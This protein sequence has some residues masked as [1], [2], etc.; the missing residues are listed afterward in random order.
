MRFRAPLVLSLRSIAFCSDRHSQGREEQYALLLKL[1]EED[2]CDRARGRPWSPRSSSVYNSFLA[3]Y[4]P[5]ACT[6]DWWSWFLAAG[7]GVYVV[8]MGVRL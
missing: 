8:F 7:I 4:Q 1:F 2:S 5:Y 3:G 6:S